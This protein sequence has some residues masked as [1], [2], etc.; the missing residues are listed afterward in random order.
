ME[1]KM[2]SA[3]FD[4]SLNVGL[5][6]SLPKHYGIEAVAR[7][8]FIPAK[9]SEVKTQVTNYIKLIKNTWNLNVRYNYSF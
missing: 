6:A 3:T 5:R 1:L 4:A 7:V 9:I 2:P 8:P